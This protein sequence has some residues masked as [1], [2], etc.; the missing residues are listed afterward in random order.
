MQPASSPSKLR[1]RI[2]GRLYRAWKRT[3]GPRRIENRIVH[4][5]VAM[6]MAIQ[7]A[8]FLCMRWAIDEAAARSMREEL[9]VGARVLERVLLD[10]GQHLQDAASALS[11]DFAF[12]EAVARR[13]R[14][15]MFSALEDHSARFKP[16][17]MVLVEPDGR[18]GAD[19]ARP[20]EAGRAFPHLALMLSGAAGERGPAIRGLDGEAVQMVAMPVKTPITSA[21]I[22]PMRAIDDAVARDLGRLVNADVAFVVQDGS[23]IQVVAT[24]LGE[25]ANATLGAPIVG[26][27]RE[28]RVESR[29][30]GPGNERRMLARQLDESGAQRIFAVLVR[31]TDGSVVPF[32]LLEL[33]ALL[34][35]AAALAITL[36]GSMRIARRISRPPEEPG[37]PARE[38]AVTEPDLMRERPGHVRG[39]RDDLG[40]IT[41]DLARMAARDPLTGLA[42]RRTLELHLA[43][44]DAEDRPVAML[45]I[46]IDGF[47]DIN[48]RHSHT[49]GDRVLQ[50]FAGLLRASSRPPDLAARYGGDEFLLA[51]AKPDAGSAEAVAQRLRAAVAAHPW[52]EVAPSL[53]VTVSIGVAEARKGLEASDVVK[54]AD[55]ALFVAKRSG[56]NQ[57]RAWT[58]DRA[59]A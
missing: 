7:L 12:R 37:A 45:M 4:L 32:Q 2:P 47:K 1:R 51:V 5:F 10:Q 40:R 57:V 29:V 31:P 56:R 25:A 35:T 8:S 22:V 6:L 53:R 21:W 39:Q 49:V 13:D 19:S 34:L 48:E 55:A 15:A 52:Q 9:D 16:S 24:T 11:A 30:A 44:W 50:A 36:A 18:I 20:G 43:G 33:V 42:N 59:E 17:R 27:V 46:D 14:K 3:V 26:M 28:R 54:R 41:G 38:I 23:S 58:G